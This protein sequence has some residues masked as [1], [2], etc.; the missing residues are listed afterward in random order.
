MKFKLNSMD[1]FKTI[2]IILFISGIVFSQG[3]PSEAARDIVKT[4]IGQEINDLNSINLEYNTNNYIIFIS[5]DLENRRM[6]AVINL[7][8]GLPADY[9]TSIALTKV[10]Y[11][12]NVFETKSVASSASVD[13]L[14]IYADDLSS[15][16]KKLKSNYPSTLREIQRI[17]DLDLSTIENNIQNI[18]DETTTFQ[19]YL[20]QTKNAWKDFSTNPSKDTFNTLN[21]NYNQTLNQVNKLITVGSKNEADLRDERSTVINDK[22]L[23]VEDKNNINAGLQTL[24]FEDNL[25]SLTILKQRMSLV[26]VYYSDEK[27]IQSWAS[28]AVDNYDFRRIKKDLN[29]LQINFGGA[30]GELKQ[31]KYKADSCGLTKSY[32]DI[33]D[34]SMKALDGSSKALESP[35][36]KTMRTEYIQLNKYYDSLNIRLNSIKSCGAEQTVTPQSNSNLPLIIGSIVIIIT[37]ILIYRALKPKEEQLEQQ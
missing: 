11:K 24:S 27:K 10:A 36:V 13:D 15:K 18:I 6:S 29:T 22:N 30:L 19:D 4:Y 34:S 14:T 2:I 35:L 1:F 17:K 23:S 32:N 25:K 12:I 5:K 26:L 33:L 3:I 16:V 20:Q 9:N 21:Q 31:N 28:D 8:V 37:V 7:D